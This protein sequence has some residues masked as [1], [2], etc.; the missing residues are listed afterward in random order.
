[1]GQFLSALR[2]P[3]QQFASSL[4]QM[5]FRLLIIILILDDCESSSS[6]AARRRIELV[7][8]AFKHRGITIMIFH[9]GE[10]PPKSNTHKK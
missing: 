4:D 7:E 5:H 6:V 10:Y 8:K 1:V 2:K 3:S 9:G